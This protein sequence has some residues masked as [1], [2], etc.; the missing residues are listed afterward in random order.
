MENIEQREV[1]NSS[2]QEFVIGPLSKESNWTMKQ[3]VN[4][5]GYREAKILEVDCICPVKLENTTREN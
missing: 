2:L 5:K 1:L 3:P 4:I